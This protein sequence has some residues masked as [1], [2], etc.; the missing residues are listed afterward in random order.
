MFRIIGTAENTNAD[1]V[2]A[3]RVLIFATDFPRICHQSLFCVVLH[4][5]LAVVPHVT[6]IFVACVG[7][8]SFSSGVVSQ[9]VRQ[10]FMDAMT[11]TEGFVTQ[12][13]RQR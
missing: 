2:G 3:T 10:E 7:F 9:E 11:T 8:A 13:V 5:T 6:L 1:R 12:K 4:L